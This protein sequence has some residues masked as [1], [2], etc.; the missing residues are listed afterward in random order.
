[1]LVLSILNINFCRTVAFIRLLNITSLCDK[2]EDDEIGLT[3][4]D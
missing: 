2:V 1:M 3:I 4:I